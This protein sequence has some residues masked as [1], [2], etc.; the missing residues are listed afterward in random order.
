MRIFVFA[1]HFPNPYKPYYETQFAQLID[2]G[3]DL[4][5]FTFGK[6]DE[7]RNARVAAYGLA[8]R[9]TYL[10]WTLRTVPPRVPGL[11]RDLLFGPR[12]V[13]SSL[14]LAWDPEQ[15]A[16]RN[17]LDASRIVHLPIDPPDLCLVHDLVTAQYLP[18]L[19]RLY[20]SAPVVL[21]FHGGELPHG[22]PIPE[23]ESLRAFAHLKRVFTNTAFSRDQVVR[24]GCPAEKVSVCPVGFRVGDYRPAASKRYRPG[25][26]LRLLTVGR[27][28]AEKGLDGALEAVKRLRRRGVEGYRL[29]IVGAGPS[30]ADLHHRI[31]VEALGEVVTC[32]GE[33]PHHL[34]L[35][36]YREA[37][38]LLLPSV[39]TD[40]WAETQACV[41]QEAMLMKLVVVASRTGGVQESLAPELRRL[42]FE[43]RDVEALSSRLEELLGLPEAELQRL[44]EAGRAFAAERYDVRHLNRRLLEQ[45]LDPRLPL[46]AERAAEA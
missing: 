13:R 21:Y 24:R 28:S 45:A 10:P 29:R 38:A 15:G 1:E 9:T 20:P 18:F 12:S 44:G 11:L 27:V 16:K 36:E 46:E 8:E 7:V 6:Y 39:A 14:S 34:L 19:G 40:R 32:C 30:L 43:A 35:K 5:I 41:V 26:Q 31:E 33:M 25:G 42:S 37:D 2:D 22:P 4:R 23:A 17:L 3:H